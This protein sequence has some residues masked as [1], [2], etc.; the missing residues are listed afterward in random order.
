MTEQIT[1]AATEFPRSIGQPAMRA[2]ADEGITTFAQL[3]TRSSKALLALHGVGPKSI[4]ILG[5]ELATRGL[6]FASD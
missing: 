2:L 5:E 6:T 3:T 1:T 4:R